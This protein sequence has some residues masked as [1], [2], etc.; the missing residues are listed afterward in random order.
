MS[1]IYFCE[2]IQIQEE[3]YFGII[4]MFIFVK[5]KK[6]MKQKELNLTYVISL[7]LILSMKK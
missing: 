2:S 5:Y 3:I 7:N 6:K 1:M 4:L